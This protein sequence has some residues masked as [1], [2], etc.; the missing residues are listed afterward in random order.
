MPSLLRTFRFR[1]VLRKS[2][3][4]RSGGAQ[5]RTG[6]TTGQGLVAGSFRADAGVSFS[7]T[8][9]VQ[10]SASASISIG[11]FAVS[12]GEL[13]SDGGFQ[14]C[15]GLDI[16]TDV[17]EYLEGGRNNGVIRRVGRGKYSP[18]VLKRGMLYNDDGE[19]V[20]DFWRWIQ[21]I[22]N[23]VRPVVRCDGLIE[24]MSVGEEVAARWEFDRALPAKI[25]GPRLDAKNG[26]I[27]LEELHLA[28]E[29]LRLVL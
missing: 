2:A 5:P 24:V 8:A 17:Q 23:G 12:T 15:S 13:L 20:K 27:A 29:G 11:A 6:V 1:V 22:A 3:S 28:H 26:E 4:V 14:E 7:G 10:A 25:S 21:D 16:E 18:V 19:V 9:G